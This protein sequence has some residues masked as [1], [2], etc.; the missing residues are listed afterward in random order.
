LP[1]NLRAGLQ[2][3]QVVHYMQMETPPEPHRGFESNVAA[4]VLRP[5]V[6]A[7]VD[8]VQGSGNNPR[9]ADINVEFNPKVGR[10]QR[11]VLLLNEFQPSSDRPAQAY[12]FSVPPRNEPEDPDETDSIAIPISGVLPGTYLVRVQVDGA[13]SPLDFDETTGQYNSPQVTLP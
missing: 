3:V 4:F 13:E 5:T 11:V 9:N 12:T 8:N 6:T 7:T 10:S 1:E 2:G